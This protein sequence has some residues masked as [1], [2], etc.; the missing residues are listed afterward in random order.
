MGNN[1]MSWTSAY[2][3]SNFSSANSFVNAYGEVNNSRPLMVKLYGTF[4]LPYQIMFSFFYQHIDGSPWGRTVSVL[5]PEEWAAENNAS[6]TGYTIKVDV[7]GTRQNESFDNLDIRLQKDFNI[8]PGTFGFYV[9]VFNLLGAYAL[10]T[11]K[12]PGGTWRPAEEGGTTGTFSPAS[13]GLRGFSGYRQIRF[14]IRYR[15]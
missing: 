12:N 5:P 2:S 11:S 7:P 14:S 6:T 3:Y 13:L 1:S 15:F 9:D 10:T 8:G 4:Y